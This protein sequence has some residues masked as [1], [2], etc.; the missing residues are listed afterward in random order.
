MFIFQLLKW[1]DYKKH[2]ITN[3]FLLFIV[4]AWCHFEIK[5]NTASGIPLFKPIFCIKNTPAQI[6][7]NK[8]MM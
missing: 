8:I 6:H 3:K 4:A 7:Y 5:K 2:K 1:H